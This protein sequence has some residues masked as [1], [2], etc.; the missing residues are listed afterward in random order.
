MELGDGGPG[1]PG[2]GGPAQ[3]LS[4][5]LWGL[6]WPPL[7]QG[8]WATHANLQAR[9]P[10]VSSPPLLGT[11]LFT[12]VHVN[13]THTHTHT[14]LHIRCKHTQSTR[15]ARAHGGQLTWTQD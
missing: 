4:Q 11:H 15:L 10:R 5:D 8:E 7:H 13:C 6:R 12:C 1:R 9:P 3:T 14:E 2:V